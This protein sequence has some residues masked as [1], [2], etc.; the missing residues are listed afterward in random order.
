MAP[1]AC[2]EPEHDTLTGE[3][4]TSVISYWPMG[5]RTYWHDAHICL[6]E[7]PTETYKHFD[8]CYSFKVL[9]RADYGSTRQLHLAA[10]NYMRNYTAGLIQ[11]QRIT[12]ERA[13]WNLTVLMFSYY[14]NHLESSGALEG[15]QT[16]MAHE[17]LTVAATL[18]CF[19]RW[20]RWVEPEDRDKPDWEKVPTISAGDFRY[21]YSPTLVLLGNTRHPTYAHPKLLG[22]CYDNVYHQGWLIGDLPARGKP[23]TKEQTQKIYNQEYEELVAWIENTIYLTRAGHIRW[24]PPPSAIWK[25]YPSEA[26][27][28]TTGSPGTSS[29]LYG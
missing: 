18:G 11:N 20:Q 16:L 7:N 10:R 8:L 29:E 28:G 27:P 13:L 25:L 23:P 9:C 17:C 24:C 4:I 1:V 26:V 12:Y 6:G 19:H 5:Q 14:I 22:R 2:R 15:H 3:G 21:K